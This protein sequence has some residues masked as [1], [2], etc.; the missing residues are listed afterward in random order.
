MTSAPTAH[1]SKTM[2]RVPKVR[3][4]MRSNF[5]VVSPETSLRDVAKILLKRKIS[6]AAV[7]DKKERFQGF[8]STHGLMLAVVDFLN[9]EI[10]VGPVQSYLDPEPPVL[11]EESSLM[12]AVEAFAKEGR[13]NFALAVLRGERLVGVVTR[14][15]VLRAAMDYFAGEKDTS[16]GTLYLSAL[17][18]MDEKPPFESHRKS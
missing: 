7:L 1:D 9:E 14:L 5:A 18:R 3:D 13:A 16:P 10:P 2:R 6:G 12:A 8:L 4:I 15:D 11:A 17:K